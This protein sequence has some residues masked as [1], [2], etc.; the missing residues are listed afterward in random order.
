MSVP[1]ISLLGGVGLRQATDKLGRC[2]LMSLHN[3]DVDQL[4]T[5]AVRSASSTT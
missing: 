2:D 4:L 1:T 5:S 3:E